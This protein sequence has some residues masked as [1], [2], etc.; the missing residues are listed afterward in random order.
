MVRIPEIEVHRVRAAT[1][2]PIS[3]YEIEIHLGPRSRKLAFAS[4]DQVR[5]FLEGVAT[6]VE[7]QGGYFNQPQIPKG[8]LRFRASGVK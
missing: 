8:G 6:L 5:A 4:E 7:L 2:P 1:T 3:V